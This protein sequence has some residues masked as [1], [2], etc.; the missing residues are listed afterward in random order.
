M[1]I[2]VTVINSDRYNNYSGDY[3][4]EQTSITV[5][6]NDILLRAFE[7]INRS[8]NNNNTNNDNKYKIYFKNIRDKSKS[9]GLR[10]YTIAKEEYDRVASLLDRI[11]RVECDKQD[12]EQRDRAF[13][14]TGKI[15]TENIWTEENKNALMGI[16][17]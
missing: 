13:K 14:E 6:S 3:V 10:E 8:T 2:K 15:Q 17:L 7:V 11:N 1:H 12:I 9:D 16:R 4:N 5:N